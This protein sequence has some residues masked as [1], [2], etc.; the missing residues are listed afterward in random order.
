M[1]GKI[2]DKAATRQALIDAG[3]IAFAELGFEGARNQAIADSAGRS[4]HS[5]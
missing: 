2:R 3:R 1:P 4:T 5:P